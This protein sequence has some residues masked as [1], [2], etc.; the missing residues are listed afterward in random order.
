M[1]EDDWIAEREAFRAECA[2][3]KR[4]LREINAMLRKMPTKDELW[5]G[6]ALM[7]IGAAWLAVMMLAVASKLW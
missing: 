3:M 6:A 5:R 1:T 4:D 2:A 7:V